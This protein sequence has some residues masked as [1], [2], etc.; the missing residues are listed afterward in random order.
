M[1]RTAKDWLKI[2][3]LL[4]DEVVIVVAALV[5]LW[6][7]NIKLPLWVVITG[8]LLL[9]LLAY[10]THKVIVPSFH[11]RQTTGSEGMISMEGEVVKAL[12][13][14]GVVRV[15]GELWKARSAEDEIPAGEIV[16][17]QGVKRLVLEVRR[18]AC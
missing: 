2:L 11:V 17:I 9:G 12:S 8:A 7:F 3:I 1:K 16:E 14:T 15:E 4:L 18:K 10:L 13:P 5:I 6:Y